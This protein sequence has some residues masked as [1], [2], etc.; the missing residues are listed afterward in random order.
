MFGLIKK[1]LSTPDFSK[2]DVLTHFPMRK[3]IKNYSKLDEQERKYASHPLTHLDFLIYNKL[4]KKPVLAIEVDGFAFHKQG[5]RQAERD[6]M[7]DA[8]LTK[9]N[10]PLL[11]FKTTESNEAE[12]LKNALLELQK[13]KQISQHSP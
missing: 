6:T 3:L 1:T 4:G 11:R 12:R 13:P 7:K 10:F 2:Y 8:I 5:T 9:Y